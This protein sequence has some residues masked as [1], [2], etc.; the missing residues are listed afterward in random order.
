MGRWRPRIMCKQGGEQR[1]WLALWRQRFWTGLWTG[2]ETGR[3]YCNGALERFWPS[4]VRKRIL[5]MP[6]GDDI[7][8]AA[9]LDPIVH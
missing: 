3:Y 2:T 1:F 9:P 4:T 5:V 7:T 8:A 6:S